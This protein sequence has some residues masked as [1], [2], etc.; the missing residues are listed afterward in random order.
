MGT[1]GFNLSF[2]TGDCNLPEWIAID[3][4]VTNVKKH[5]FSDLRNNALVF[6]SKFTN[7][8]FCC[9]NND[10][11]F[12][13]YIFRILG[14]IYCNN[15]G[16]AIRRP[17]YRNITCCSIATCSGFIPYYLI[18]WHSCSNSRIPSDTLD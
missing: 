2:A 15:N 11:V 13:C 10:I 4:I 6:V 16:R 3:L 1:P 5:R 17:D 9:S 12:W 18:F 14:K 8:Q 7:Q